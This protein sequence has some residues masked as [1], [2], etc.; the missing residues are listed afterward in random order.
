[1]KHL[2][3]TP[4]FICDKEKKNYCVYI[5]TDSNYFHAEPILKKLY[6]N[7]TEMSNEEKDDLVEKLVLSLL[8]QV[9]IK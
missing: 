8:Q 9:K 5:D 7:F 1:M 3:D 2:E 4:E 6:P